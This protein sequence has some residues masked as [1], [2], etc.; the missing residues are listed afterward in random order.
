VD[1]FKEFVFSLLQNHWF[2]LIGLFVAFALP[3]CIGFAFIFRDVR[4][5]LVSGRVT[6]GSKSGRDTTYH[7]DLD[8]LNFWL[9]VSFRAALAVGVFCLPLLPFVRMSWPHWRAVANA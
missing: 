6:L 4:G 3:S 7:R 2:D 5:A 1:N 9:A 8:S